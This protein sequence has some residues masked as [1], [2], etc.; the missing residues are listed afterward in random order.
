MANGKAA[1]LIG[2]ALGAIALTQTT[3]A[4]EGIPTLPIPEPEIGAKIGEITIGV[5]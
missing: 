2:L 1:I 3:K 4:E 5:L